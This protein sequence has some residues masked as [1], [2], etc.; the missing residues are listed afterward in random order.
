MGGRNET[1]LPLKPLTSFSC[2]STGKLLTSSLRNRNLLALF[3][4]LKKKKQKLPLNFESFSFTSYGLI[5]EHFFLYKL[6]KNSS[7]SLKHN[8]YILLTP[9]LP[10]APTT[11]TPLK[12]DDALYSSFLYLVSERVTEERTKQPWEKPYARVCGKHYKLLITTCTIL[13][14][15]KQ[16]HGIV[17]TAALIKAQIWSTHYLFLDGDFSARMHGRQLVRQVWFSSAAP[18]HTYWQHSVVKWYFQDLQVNLVLRFSLLLRDFK[19][20]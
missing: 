18:S 11:T 9:F 17:T 5:Y 16:S 14:S 13:L 8:S 1:L 4:S 19:K 10:Q 7:F 6:R 12:G 2:S 15:R 3:I 20:A